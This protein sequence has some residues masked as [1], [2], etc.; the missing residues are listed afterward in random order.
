MIGEIK[1]KECILLSVDTF[2]ASDFFDPFA[3]TINSG[4][5][6]YKC[7]HLFNLY[8]NCKFEGLYKHFL[9]IYYVTPKNLLC[10]ATT[11]FNQ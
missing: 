7:K 11:D 2:D 9:K 5:E 4:E 1:F 8:Q 10:D 6:R 3:V